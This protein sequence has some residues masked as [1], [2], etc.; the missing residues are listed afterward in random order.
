MRQIRTI[1]D[2]VGLDEFWATF[3]EGC[4]Q[5]FKRA[6]LNKKLSTF[7]VRAIEDCIVEFNYLTSIYNTEESIL[8]NF[9]INGLKEDLRIHISITRDSYIHQHL[10]VSLKWVQSVATRISYTLQP[11]NNSNQNFINNT[12]KFTNNNHTNNSE[13]HCHNKKSKN[14]YL[15]NRENTKSFSRLD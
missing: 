3:S 6:S 11:A 5:S 7:K 12:K 1:E 9:F 10:P 2:S 8:I 14:R 4:G 13:A 15:D